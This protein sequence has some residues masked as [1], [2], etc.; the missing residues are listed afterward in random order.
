[1]MPPDAVGREQLAHRGDGIGFVALRVRV[2]EVELLAEHTAI[3][4]DDLLRD[5]R[6]LEHRLTQHRERTGEAGEHPKRDMAG[7][8]GLDG[9]AA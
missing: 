2:T 4:V 6:A 7:A 9:A 1:M 3:G 5:L 8:V